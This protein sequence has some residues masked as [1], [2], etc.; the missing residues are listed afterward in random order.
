MKPK[1]SKLPAS[2]ANKLSTAEDRAL[3]LLSVSSVLVGLG[4]FLSLIILVWVSDR[5]MD[6][7]KWLRVILLV[8]ATIMLAWTLISFVRRRLRLLRGPNE[9]VSI[10]QN[11]YP[12]LGDSLQGAVELADESTRPV[13]VSARLCEA[14]VQQVAT[15]VE[16]LD[17]DAAVSRDERN[18]TLRRVSFAAAFTGAFLLAD[19]KALLSSLQRALMPFSNIERHT[20][21]RFK[22]MPTELY[23]ARGE[24]V[25]IDIRLDLNAKVVPRKISY[26]YD[27][28][29]SQTAEV[30]DGV[31]KIQMRGKS[32]DA[33]ISFSAMPDARATVIIRQVDRPTLNALE[34]QLNLPAYLGGSGSRKSAINGGALQV[35]SGASFRLAGQTSSMLS[36]ASIERGFKAACDI[37]GKDFLSPEI[38][39]P[40]DMINLD[41]LLKWTDT[42]GISSRSG[43]ALGIVWV[44]DAA[45]LVEIHD[46]SSVIAVLESESIRLP[47]LASDDNGLKNLSIDMGVQ[48]TAADD[49]G[50]IRPLH[51]NILDG[52]PEKRELA[53]DYMFRPRS[54]K[55]TAGHRVAVCAT[56]LDYLPGREASRSSPIVIL[57]LSP[58]EHAKLIKEQLDAMQARL[59]DLS[60][61]EKEA[62]EMSK[63]LSKENLKTPEGQRKL[64]D[65]KEGEERRKSE[66][67]K[68]LRE[69]AELMAEAAKNKE[70]P[71]DTMLQW[72]EAFNNLKDAS[73]DNMSKA[74]AKLDK[75][76]QNASKPK[77]G[78]PSDGKPK[79]EKPKD[80]KDG[81]PSDGKP[82]DEKPKD[83]KDGNPSDG[84]PQDQ[85]EDEK[86]DAEEAAEEQEKA[87]EKIADAAKNNAEKEK[88]AQLASISKRLRKVANEERALS[89][90]LNGLVASTIGLS[91]DKLP[92]ATAKTFR[93]AVETQSAQATEASRLLSDLRYFHSLTKNEDYG[94][95]ADEMESKKASEALA[96]ITDMIAGNRPG[97]ASAEN[98]KLAAVFDDWAKIIEPK[99]EEGGEGGGKP[100]PPDEF[101][102]ELFRVLTEQQQIYNETR[103]LEDNK[104]KLDHET[105]AEEVAKSQ[106]KLAGELDQLA[107]EAPKP[108][109]GKALD[110][111]IDLMKEASANLL[112]HASDQALTHEATVIEIITSMLQK[113]PA[114]PGDKKDK[115]KGQKEDQDE[116]MQAMLQALQQQMQKGQKAG[117]EQAGMSGNVGGTGV[118]GKPAEVGGG[119]NERRPP[120]GSGSA[121]LIEDVP[122]E[123]REAFE[124]YYKKA[125]PKI[126][127]P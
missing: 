69:L 31:A 47:L 20:L 93:A 15:S 75:A 7:P 50:I 112:Q 30:T 79:D 4:I 123:Y 53:N 62:A 13:S 25:S 39:Q 44:P 35:I 81:K 56:A 37:K 17:F 74:A 111:S 71:K 65:A 119:V 86:K 122:A 73:K 11:H 102:I 97:Q 8:V 63:Q 87:A 2:L 125:E 85:E 64:Q 83:G 61:K 117:G 1:F 57:V 89:T 41:L 33:K 19:H 67:E 60:L 95:V 82:K 72:K 77:D 84:E 29:P 18:R 98:L 9:I 54:L 27:N 43:Q 127:A 36:N 6:T 28:E 108:E 105:E 120:A 109:I 76:A 104:L 116:A 46:V 49:N 34:A 114:K 68:E 91:P 5:I 94:K 22:D 115:Q 24:D 118:N 92:P 121:A 106:I 101:A 113:P 48:S 66:L 107:G 10:V 45:P 3:D 51:V 38:L 26:S 16:P 40:K 99:P 32:K 55:I 96:A 103:Y 42:H 110:A 90:T 21:A 126:H 88:K 70:F 12:K 23:V 59:E 58:E 124:N 52:D 14:A 78:K 80:G 100:K